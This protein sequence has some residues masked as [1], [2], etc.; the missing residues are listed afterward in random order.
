M[1]IG[2]N[3]SII[4]AEEAVIPVYDHGFLYGIGLFETFRTYGGRPFLLERHLERLAGGCRELGIRCELEPGALRVWLAEVM[5]ANHLEEAY[6][7]LTVTAGEAGLGLPQDDYE[8]PN[9]L[10]LVKPL[11]EPSERLYAEGKELALLETRRNTPEGPVRFKSLH[12]MNNILAKRELR[13]IGAAP[14]AEGL[15]LTKEG[16]LSEGI[17]SNLFFLKDGIVHTPSVDTG[18]LPGITRARVMELAA[19]AGVRVQEGHYTWEG[20]KRAQ[21]V[22]ITNSIQEVVPITTLRGDDGARTQVGDGAAGPTTTMLLR[23][24]RSEAGA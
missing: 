7:R 6:V 1:K 15:M 2:W 23:A 18:I 4:H 8:A 5:A 24:Y 21:E 17:V 12:Y 9:R 11:P 3:G 16:W 19:A 20:L 10:L 22:W 13:G 14:N